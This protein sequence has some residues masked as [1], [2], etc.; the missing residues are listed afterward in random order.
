MT[1]V[2]AAMVE[3]ALHTYWSMQAKG[4]PM[5]TAMRAVLEAALAEARTEA[6]V[7]AQRAL[8]NES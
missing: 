3:A 7:S 2:T 1:R 6:Y 4:M 8:G 5:A